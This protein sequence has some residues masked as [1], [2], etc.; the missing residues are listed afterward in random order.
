MARIDQVR[1]ATLQAQIEENRQHEMALLRKKTN[2]MTWQGIAQ[3]AITGYELA[4]C[5][6]EGI[7]GTDA[8]NRAYT[9][10]SAVL[11]KIGGIDRFATLMAQLSRSSGPQDEDLD[12]KLFD[13]S[14]YNTARA[15]LFPESGVRTTKRAV[16]AARHARRAD[17]A[18]IRFDQQRNLWVCI[19][20]GHSD[21]SECPNAFAILSARNLGR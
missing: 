9:V 14:G 11:R 3:L 8:D 5:D 21:C 17:W 12:D 6:E 4:L 20:H 10:S 15:R 16:P 7:T 18:D 1:C 2:G 19:A 13:Q